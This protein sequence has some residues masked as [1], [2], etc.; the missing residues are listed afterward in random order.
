MR[1]PAAFARCAAVPCAEFPIRVA[2]FSP[3]CS[4]IPFDESTSNPGTAPTN[5]SPFDVHGKPNVNRIPDISRPVRHG[6]LL[7]EA[8]TSVQDGKKFF[9]VAVTDE[10]YT[11]DLMKV[12]VKKILTLTLNFEVK[13]NFF[14]CIVVFYSS[15]KQNFSKEP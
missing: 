1:D 12:H 5:V 3:V 10:F 4:R 13:K 15:R 9:S 14:F 11:F 6:V 8:I 2:L 7:R